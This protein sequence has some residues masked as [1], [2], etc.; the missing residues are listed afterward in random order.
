MLA[1]ALYTLGG[2]W[3]AGAKLRW[4][5]IRG[6][7]MTDNLGESVYITGS[8]SLLG[9]L[10]LSYA[11]QNLAFGHFMPLARAELL[12][13]FNGRGVSRVE[14]RRL[15][16]LSLRGTSGRLTLGLT[17]TD[18]TKGLSAALAGF[19][20]GGQE[21]GWGLKFNGSLRF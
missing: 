8:D 2:S 7:S 19:A 14:G 21:D 16:A 6:D 9:T 5:H 17:Y 15:N 11:A 13:E 1:G 3:T 12:H 18:E 4:T 20:Q 10:G